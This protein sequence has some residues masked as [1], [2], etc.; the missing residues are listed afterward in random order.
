MECYEYIATY[1]D[2]LCNAGQDPGKIMQTLKEDYKLKVKGD[3]PMSHFLGTEY[4][5]DKDKTPV[6]QPKKHIDRLLESSQ[7]MFKQDRPKNMRTPLGKNDHS[8]LDDTELLNEESIHHYLTMIGHLQWL[9]TL[10]R[11]HIHAQ[12]TTMSTFR[13]ASRKGH[14]ERLERIYGY[15]PEDQALFNQVHKRG[16]RLQLPS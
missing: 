12:V 4:T 2:D 5:R 6:C 15:C 8:E 1:V 16:T 11:F 9:V 10:V 13:S 14:L 7:F 3:G